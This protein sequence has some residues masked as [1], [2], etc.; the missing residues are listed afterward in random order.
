MLPT[1]KVNDAFVGDY[2]KAQWHCKIHPHVLAKKTVS[3]QRLGNR[4]IFAGL[5]GELL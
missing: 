3:E 4:D 1:T 2:L 5:V